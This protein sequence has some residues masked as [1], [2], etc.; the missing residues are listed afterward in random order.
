MELPR[1]TVTL[2]FT[3]IEG[4]TRLLQ[5]LG[6]EAYVPALELHRKLLREAFGR[7]GGVEV[8]MQGDSF[9]YAFATALQGVAAAAEAQR[10]LAECHWEQEPIRVRIGLHTGEPVVSGGLYAGLD[11][12][13]AAR[14]MSAGHGGQVLLSDGTC[15]AVAGSLPDGF[16]L[17]DLGE[18]RLKDLSHP[19]RLHQLTAP[20]LR[21]DFPPLATLYATNLPIPPTPFLGRER[22]LAE[23]TAHLARADVR[24]LTL[25]GPGGTGKTRLAA[26]AAAAVAEGYRDGVWWVPLASLTDHRLVLQA[27]E[28]ALGAE[29]PLPDHV[30]DRSL[31]LFFDNFEQVVEAAADVAGLLEACPNLDVLVTSREPLRIRAEHEYAV[32]P[33][34]PDDAASLFA[35]RAQAVVPGFEANGSVEEI[36][37][38]LDH[39]PLAIELAAVRVRMLSAPA[40][41]E[42]LE[43]RLPVLTG[44]PRDVPARQ[45][46]LRG[47]IAW[48]HELLTPAERKVFARLAVF[49]GGCRLDAAEAVADADLDTLQSLVEKSLLR[50]SGDRFSMLET[51]REYA[52][53]ELTSLD[54]DGTTRRGHA[55]FYRHLAERAYADLRGPEQATL[56]ELLAEEHDNLRAALATL[57]DRGKAEEAVS[58]V[59]ALARFWTMRGHVG[60][61]RR[62]LELVLGGTDVAPGRPRALRS[63]AILAM[64]QGDVA[65]AE[66]AAA[67]ALEL[68]RAAGDED[69]AAQSL[70]LLAD[71]VAYRGDLPAAAA[72]YEEAAE[73]ARRRGDRLEL[74]LSLYNLGHA[75][76][77]Q[78]DLDRA[79]G[80]FEDALALFRELEDALGEGG[81]LQGLVPIA[82]ERGD[83]A[84]AFSLLETAAALFRRIGS[85]G[86][87]LDVLET[88]AGL[89]ART[90]A[91]E[92]AARL[93]GAHAALSAE[94]G[95]DRAH[96][97]E[98]AER[99]E[100]VA[101]ARASLGE[102][103]FEAAWAEGAAMT[104]DDAV[105]YALERSGVA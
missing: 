94:L 89:F 38:R 93:W 103:A 16:D 7:H 105:S 69:G 74:A 46:T 99:D 18:H 80:C 28:E 48:S 71:V 11:V 95:R 19:L 21:E 97:L 44:G 50:R 96:A 1:G 91:G 33:L 30:G 65:P 59:G 10:A 41:L 83:P 6:T 49:A 60:E 31:L 15:A 76:R 88:L 57:V 84:R 90:A 104:L 68:D 17:R 92:E 64:E 81:S 37:R 9:H 22:E 73:S 77:L 43:R 2:L 27:A 32:P 72:L 100:A 34:A 53:E 54:P 56:L 52:A 87:L 35:A 66:T 3:D 12:H 101:A 47:A 40:L 29:K 24:L 39:L 82:V 98:S 70:G 4:S 13:Q 25:T 36:C 20:G 58:L 51:I 5:E 62:W 75:A 63:L 86:G 45:R 55:A 23:V 102:A 42:R 67:E 78:G 85:V 26:Q 61:G 8:E 79:E 14:V